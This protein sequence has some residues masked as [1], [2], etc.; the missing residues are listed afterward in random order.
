MTRL[1]LTR[2]LALALLLLAVAAGPASASAF[3]GYTDPYALTGGLAGTITDTH[4][5]P[6]GGLR[7]EIGGTGFG[8]GSYVTEDDGTFSVHLSPGP[9]VLSVGDQ[10]ATRVWYPGVSEFEDA[11]KIQ[12]GT[13]MTTVHWAIDRD[14]T[15]ATVHGRILD[16]LH[17]GV[18]DH[19]VDAFSGP[20]GKIVQSAR[21]DAQGDY[22]L[23]GL[24]PG[25]YPLRLALG[26]NPASTP[27]WSFGIDVKVV[28]GEHRELAPVTVPQASYDPY[29]LPI[30]IRGLA[31]PADARGRF[32][33]R[34]R[35][36]GFVPCAG[37]LAVQATAGGKARTVA[38][39]PYGMPAR[40]GRD[41]RIAG[42]L[43]AAGRRLL[44]R[45][46][47]RLPV[48]YVVTTSPMPVFSGPVSTPGVLR[49]AAPKPAKAKAK[50]KKKQ[51]QQ[52]RHAHR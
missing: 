36:P 6:L 8:S 51:Q 12:V 7:F 27:R 26:A 47:R 17:H 28:A 43:T 2:A 3:D 18:P 19:W 29:P 9:H 22:T 49:G 16:V 25:T 35:C 23:T 31:A 39:I 20:N 46:H 21:T 50:K 11:T 4:D 37:T 13:T 10:P 34:V 1:A 5:R 15:L 40:P 45:G 32:A 52:Q 48:A 44:A 30:G 42:R 38:T 14:G 24:A 41:V 33:L